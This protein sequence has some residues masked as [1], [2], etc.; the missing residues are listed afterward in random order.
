[1]W[2]ETSSVFSST[3]P[4]RL[5]GAGLFF[6]AFNE[7]FCSF[8]HSH[9]LV[10]CSPHC[11]PQPANSPNFVGIKLVD[12]PA[13]SF[14]M[15]SFVQDKKSVFLGESA[16]ANPDPDASNNETPQHRVSVRAL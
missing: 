8:G 5:V 1:M 4:A 2:R 9:R 12:I 7:A 16:C 3:C 10:V 6:D 13:G 11:R 14:S 15:G